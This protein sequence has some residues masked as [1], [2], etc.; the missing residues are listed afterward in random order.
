[1]QIRLWAW[2]FKKAETQGVGRP[3]AELEA[4]RAVGLDKDVEKRDGGETEMIED[5]EDVRV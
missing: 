1:M 5:V 3:V 4:G 2:Q